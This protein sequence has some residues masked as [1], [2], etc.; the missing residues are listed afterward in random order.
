MP[1]LLLVAHVDQLR[2]SALGQDVYIQ[3]GKIFVLTVFCFID[4]PWVSTRL[5]SQFNTWKRVAPRTHLAC[6]KRALQHVSEHLHQPLARHP[7][8]DAG[9]RFVYLPHPQTRKQDMS[10]LPRVNMRCTRWHF[11]AASIWT[12]VARETPSNFMAGAT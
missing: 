8:H 2:G 10:T 11:G 4:S 12:L 7:A 6:T 5:I 3:T 9:E 1:E